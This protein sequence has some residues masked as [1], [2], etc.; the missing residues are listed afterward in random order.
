MNENSGPNIRIRVLRQKEV[1]EVA[2][3]VLNNKSDITEIKSVLHRSYKKLDQSAFAEREALK[4]T[5][6]AAL[7]LAG[8]VNQLAEKIVLLE[9]RIETLAKGQRT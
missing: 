2:K 5:L 7:L 4:E 6:N 3:K 1:D 8:A 9:G